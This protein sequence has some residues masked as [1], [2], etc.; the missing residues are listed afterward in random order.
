MM[1]SQAKELDTQRR[2]PQN[3]LCVKRLSQQPYYD[4][5]VLP[6]IVGREN[7]G[8]LVWKESQD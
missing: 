3:L 5:Q 4:R 2:C 6:L 7:D 1:T 8:I